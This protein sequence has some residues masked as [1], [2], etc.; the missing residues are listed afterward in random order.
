MF[1]SALGTDLNAELLA[2]RSRNQKDPIRIL[3]E[4]AEVAEARS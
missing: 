2:R 4:D 3:Q 1:V